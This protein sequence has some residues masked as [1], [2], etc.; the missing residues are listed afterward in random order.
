MMRLNLL[1]DEFEGLL[2]IILKD[3]K[4]YYFKPPNISWGILFPLV[5]AL[6]FTLKSPMASRELAPGLV[7]TA[8]LFGTTSMEAI[9][10]TFEKRVK[11]LERLIMAPISLLTLLIAKILGGVIFGFMISSIMVMISILILNC[12]IMDPILFLTALLLTLFALS[13]LGALIAFSVKE[14]FEA[15][16]LSN[17]FRF[18]MLFLSGVF[19]PVN[20]MPLPLQIVAWIFPLTYSVE[21]FKI[22]MSGL[23]T[24]TYP[25]IDLLVLLGYSLLLTYLSLIAIRKSLK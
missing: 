7:A 2:H 14:V 6:A 17:Y 21:A 1:I 5:L 24:S 23:S 25:T 16:T 13:S 19:L 18:P 20:S 4:A 8:A 22:S 3:L 10:V 11:A 9:V 15:Q 12:S